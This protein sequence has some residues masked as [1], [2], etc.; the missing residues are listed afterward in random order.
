MT[1]LDSPTQP[2]AP[3]DPVPDPTAQPTPSPAPAR[4]ATATWIVGLA[5]AAV[6]GAVLFAGG[7]LAA[8][9][10]RQSAT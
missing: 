2:H 6:V 3:G 4:T 7:Y 10:N 9:G 5:L 8:G 1:P